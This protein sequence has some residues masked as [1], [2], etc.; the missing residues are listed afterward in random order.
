[1]KFIAVRLVF[2]MFIAPAMVQAADSPNVKLV[3]KFYASF[4]APSTPQSDAKFMTPKLIKLLY[5]EGECQRRNEEDCNLDFD[6]FWA[7]QDPSAEALKI[8]KSAKPEIV[9][10]TYRHNYGKRELVTMKYRIEQTKQGPRIADIK[11]EDGS[12]LVNL[13]EQP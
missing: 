5:R 3:K 9:V 4:D 1:M 11:Y 7:S 10:V 8:A 12:S 13:L 6:P 2:S